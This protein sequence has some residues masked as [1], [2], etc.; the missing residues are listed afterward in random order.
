V[1][2]VV[3]AKANPL[4]IAAN[5]YD[6]PEDQGEAPKAPAKGRHGVK[7]KTMN[8]NDLDNNKIMSV[9]A[10]KPAPLQASSAVAARGP[11]VTRSGGAGVIRRDGSAGTRPDDNIAAAA[12]LALVFKG[13]MPNNA[14]RAAFEGFVGAKVV[15]RALVALPNDTNDEDEPGHNDKEYGLFVTQDNN[16]KDNETLGSKAPKVQQGSGREAH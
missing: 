5:K 2:T 11:P 6:D 16:T 3:S 1:Y 7:A 13:C 8:K 15:R 14:V 9:G 4:S 10:K 12:Q